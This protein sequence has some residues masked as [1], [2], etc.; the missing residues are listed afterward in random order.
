MNRL[1]Y[2]S[3]SA[4]RTAP[5]PDLIRQLV[6]SVQSLRAYNR[7]IPILV[8]TFG[9]VPPELA[10]A[11]APYEVAFC[12]KGSYE[13]CLARES[14]RGWQILSQYPLLHKFLNFHEI[15]ALNKDQV[16]FLDCDTLFFQDVEIL[17]SRYAD[18]DAYAREEPTCA[19]SHYGYNPAYVDEAALRQWADQEGIRTPPPFNLGVVLLNHGLWNKL[20]ALQPTLVSYAWR[21]A[22]WMAQHPVEGVAASYGEGQ[23]IP[24]L[25]QYFDR[26]ADAED[27]RRSL[28]YPSANRWIL[29]QVA[30]WFT[31]GHV[32][33]LNYADFSAHDVVQNGEFS[34]HPP[35]ESDWVVCHYFSQNTERLAQWIDQPGPGTALA[36]A[37]PD[38]AVFA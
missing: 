24:Y 7:T 20:A 27:V 9:D 14:L 8:F 36:Q 28:P 4:S 34:S 5:R 33:G 3:L 18:A 2:Y 1:V 17:F 13:A 26:L 11:L 19:R 16:L 38:A 22:V 30:L 32:A 21:F 29:D 23:G 15:A 35:A 37:T 31:L 10:P 12:H 6:R 25:R